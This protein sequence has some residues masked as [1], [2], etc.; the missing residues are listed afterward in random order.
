MHRFVALLR[1]HLA[2]KIEWN[3]R[4]FLEQPGLLENFPGKSFYKNYFQNVD[5]SPWFATPKRIQKGSKNWD[6]KKNIFR[7]VKNADFPSPNQL[8]FQN[9]YI[10]LIFWSKTDS[11]NN[12]WKEISWKEVASRPGYSRKEFFSAIFRPRAGVVLFHGDTVSHDA[13]QKLFQFL[14]LFLPWR[15]G[16]GIL[17]EIFTY[18]NLSCS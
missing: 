16:R 5:N 12:F 14:V 13:S 1:W 3:F 15:R 4:T 7:P 2:R 11:G 18:R 8:L 10:R 9:S 17:E 6:Q